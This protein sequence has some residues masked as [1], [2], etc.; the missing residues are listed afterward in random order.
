[1]QFKKY[2]YE[3]YIVLFLASLLTFGVCIAFDANYIFS[4]VLSIWIA[5]L[6]YSLMDIKNNV[7]IFLF[8]VSF[9][10]LLLGREVAHYFF[11]FSRHY[12]Y[13]TTI[14]EKSYYLLI[15]SLIGIFLGL[16]LAGKFNIEFNKNLIQDYNK[17]SKYTRNIFLFCLFIAIFRTIERIQFVMSVGYVS[18]YTME[19]GE[20][21]G[22]LV[23]FSAFCNLALCMYLAS[24]PP[25]K[26]VIKVFGVYEFYLLLT[27][28]TG[29]RA[30]MVIGNFVMIMYF[31]I[32][33][34]SER[35]WVSKR[36]INIGLIF[37]PLAFILLYLF[38]FI[39]TGR[40]IESQGLLHSIVDFFD[41]QGGSINNIKRDIYYKDSIADLNLVSF[42]S[43]HNALFENAL[44]RQFVDVKVYTNNSIETATMSNSLAHRLSYL[45]Y[46][47]WYL[48]G[49]GTGSSY[50]AELFHDFGY[51]G[52]LLGNIIY[53][54]ILKKV[55]QINFKNI[56]RDTILLVFCFSILYAPRNN[57]D[58]FITEVMTLHKLVFSVILVLIY[59]LIYEKGYKIKF[60]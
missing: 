42:N 7:G 41:Q 36:L 24:I 30:T 4:I 34:R 8:M 25:K 35:D 27:M 46:G 43:V 33:H 12:I 38:D 6:I 31:V 32:R 9:Y 18:S 39:R 57:F 60:K 53:G 48:Y 28:F 26:E 2:C 13:S 56:F 45:V 50:I 10:V 37:L 54:F 49:H 23:Y 58:G 40:T 20:K 16:K 52:V 1:M 15:I 29:I 44:V 55:S 59:L 19:Y 22:F 5:L 11:G 3:N 51:I 14:D 47:D 17:F 21:F